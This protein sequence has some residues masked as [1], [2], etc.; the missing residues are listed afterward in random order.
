MVG[1]A[2]ADVEASDV[3]RSVSVYLSFLQAKELAGQERA[4]GAVGFA[5]GRFDAARLRHL[6]VLGDDQD[7]YFRIIAAAVTP[8]QAAFMR[9]T[10]AGDAVDA[11]VRMRRV[12]ADD[13]LEGHLGG[14]TGADWFKAT[15]ARIDLLKTV[16]DRMASDLM[17]QTAGIRHA[18]ESELYLSLAAILVLLGLTAAISTVMI[19][20]IVRPLGAL[21]RT[22]RRLAERDMTAEIGGLGRKDEIGAM[23]GS[24]QVFKDNMIEADRLRAEQEAQKQRAAAERRAAMLDLAAQFEAKVANLV[25]MLASSATEMEA[26]ARAMS[27]TAGETNGQ[28]ASVAAAAEEASAGVQTVAASAEELSLP[29]SARSPARWRS[30]RRSPSRRWPT[31][32]APTRRCARWPRAPSGSARWSS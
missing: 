27:A 30:P 20:A 5:A 26:T 21:N 7:L 13:G 22:M 25:G 12:A 15:T 2:A 9:R 11:V 32:G 19:R 14:V 31:R 3:A 4:V 10:V 24:V 16:E 8:A 17:A 18:A 28:A 1:A 23:A 6:A 29:R